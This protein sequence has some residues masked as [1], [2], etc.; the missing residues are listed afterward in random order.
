MQNDMEGGE[1]AATLTPAQRMELVQKGYNPMSPIDVQRYYKN[2]RP[3]EGLSELAGVNKYKNLGGGTVDPRDN[4]LLGDFERETGEAMDLDGPLRIGSGNPREDVKGMMEN[5]GDS[6][7]NLDDKI[8]RVTDRINQA[9]QR[10]PQRQLPPARQERQQ[11]TSDRR[12]IQAPRQTLPL[13]NEAAKARKAGY[14]MG[15]RYLN[16][17]VENIQRPSA[18]NRALLMKEMNSLVLVEDKI[19]PSI[20]REYRQG[21]AQAEAEFY[22]NIKKK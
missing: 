14:T 10:Q 2:Q 12:L 19:E 18:Q 13:I 16:A 20:I 15:V 9:Q 1:L 7:G 6:L 11:P 4:N 22:G 21:I 3:Q 5:Y 17:F 8:G